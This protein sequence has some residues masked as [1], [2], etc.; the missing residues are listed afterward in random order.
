MKERE[1]LKNLK[2]KEGVYQQ[3]SKNADMHLLLIYPFKFPYFPF[4]AKNYLHILNLRNNYA[5]F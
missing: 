2:T 1:I 5:Y 3:K 4:L